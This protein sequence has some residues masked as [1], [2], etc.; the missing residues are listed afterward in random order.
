MLAVLLGISCSSLLVAQNTAPVS[1]ITSE[2]NTIP[3]TLQEKTIPNTQEIPNFLEQRIPELNWTINNYCLN[4]IGGDSRPFYYS[5][6]LQS[7]DVLSTEICLQAT[8]VVQVIPAS[9]VI[10]LVI[11]ADA[12]TPKIPKNIADAVHILTILAK[13]YNT[14]SEPIIR[15]IS[16]FA[17]TT[18][19][20]MAVKTFAQFGMCG[21][22]SN[23]IAINTIKKA[24]LSGGQI[25]I[26][27]HCL[28]S[29]IKWRNKIG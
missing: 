5:E 22:L 13:L 18:L 26:S 29:I 1:P 6:P 3:A 2:R 25:L 4:I 24:V 28:F 9:S 7:I 27:E 11:Q 21:I 12:D 15:H 8:S 23:S 16:V 20:E 14:K 19:A 10:R 17:S